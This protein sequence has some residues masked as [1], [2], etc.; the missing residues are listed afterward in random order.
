MVPYDFTALEV[1]DLLKTHAYEIAE[2]LE[3]TYDDLDKEIKEVMDD[4]K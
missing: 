1:E 4:G 2:I 3:K